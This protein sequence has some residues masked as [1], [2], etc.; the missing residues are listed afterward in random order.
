MPPLNEVEVYC[1]AH[2]GR[3]VHWSV[4]RS[5]GRYT[6]PCPD[7][8]LTQNRARITKFGTDIHLGM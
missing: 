2:V 3:F 6:K 1:F 8:N 5:M 7:D 4:S